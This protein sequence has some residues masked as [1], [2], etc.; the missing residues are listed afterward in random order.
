MKR[1]LLATALGAAFLASPAAARDG[2][3][4]VGIE[5][6]VMFPKNTRGSVNVDYTTTQSPI[7]SP[8]FVGPADVRYDNAYSIDNKRGLDIDVIAGYDFGMFRLEGELGWKRTKIKGLT[9]DPAFVS[10]LNTGL[11][12]PATAG[13]P[14]V[15]GSPA[16]TAGS[17]ALNE[18][19][20][21]LS[22]MVNGL[23]DFGSDNVNFYVGG[24]AGRA[25]AKFAGIKDS[26]WAFQ[27]IA[28]VR[29]ALSESI[30]LGLKY[31]Y[32]RTARLNLADDTAATLAGNADRTTV[33][34]NGVATP[35]VR[36]TNASVTT[37]FDNKFRS[38]S[39]MASLIFNFGA[40]REA[41]PPPPPPA[42][43]APPPP[44]A[45]ATQ[46]CPDGS[47]ILATDICPAP[48]PPP[49]PAPSGERG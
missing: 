6:G 26:A 3:P 30:D 24:G 31:R 18:R 1:I 28:G 37:D 41:A 5:G 4:Y 29:F 34:V 42:P 20:R 10:G 40:A 9:V 45:P 16:L 44:P 49:P 7:T 27:G 8:L 32:F 11:N 48:P 43:I 2:S 19:T 35:I 12:L 13:D 39:L 46:T 15:P 17:F 47:V 38:H 23:V 36:T 22:G 25:R 21:I 14:V 33:L